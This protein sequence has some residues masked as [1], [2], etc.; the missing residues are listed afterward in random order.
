[1]LFVC[2]ILVSNGTD[3]YS[4]VK[5]IEVSNRT[6][7]YSGVKRIEVTSRTDPYSGVKRIVVSNHIVVSNQLSHNVVYKQTVSQ[8]SI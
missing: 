3:T 1:M 8:C 7:P 4:G 5:R 2:A 6:D